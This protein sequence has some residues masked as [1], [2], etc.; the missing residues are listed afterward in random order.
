MKSASGTIF[1]FSARREIEGV[2]SSTLVT[3][4]PS[5]RMSGKGPHSPISTTTPDE[6]EPPTALHRIGGPAI[7]LPTERWPRHR[8]RCMQHAF[9]VDLEGVD[10]PVTKA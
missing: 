9:T 4:S 2:S 3:R 6:D 7:G 8:G 10:L 1:S 5:L